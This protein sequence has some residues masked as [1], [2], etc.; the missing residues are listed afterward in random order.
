VGSALLASPGKVSVSPDGRRLAIADTGHDQVMVCLVDGLLLSVHMGLVQPQGVRFDGDDV[1]VCDTGASRVVRTT[2]DVVADDV[3]SPLDLIPEDRGWLVAEAGRHRIGRIRAWEHQVRP[4]AGSGT[5]GFLDGPWHKAQLAGPAG[6]ATFGDGVVVADSGSNAVRLVARS[7]DVTTVIGPGEGLHQPL[8]VATAAARIYV[9]DT[10]NSALK[11]WQDG[12]L[13]A[14]PL[15]AGNGSP[16]LSEPGG[17]DVLPD[18]RLVVADTG[19]DR[20]IF[21]DPTGG[22]AEE[23]DI[24]D[25]WATCPD[26]PEVTGRAGQPVRVPFEVYLAGETLDPSQPSPVKVTAQARPPSL[27]TGGQVE[28][29]VAEASGSVKARAGEALE[30]WGLLLVEATATTRPDQGGPP[31]VRVFRRR[32]RFWVS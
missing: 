31:S 17:L 11:V 28:W 30:G 1:V 27:L 19:N 15:T 4:A 20:V 5:R 3:A 24:D 26:G 13:H 23:L 29:D 32:H 16:G 8:G 9:A 10:L 22:A 7:G 14:L 6:L 25:S 21:V 2:G 12:A 18:G